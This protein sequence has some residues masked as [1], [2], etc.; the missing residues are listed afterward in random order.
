LFAEK[1]GELEFRGGPTCG[2]RGGVGEFGLGEKA[3]KVGERLLGSR[4]IESGLLQGQGALAL[5]ALAKPKQ[6][7]EGKA[8][9]HGR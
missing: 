1:I 9:S 7:R 6:R 4:D 8:E 5:E 2:E 3:V